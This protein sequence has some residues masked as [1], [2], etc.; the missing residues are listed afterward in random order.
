MMTQECY[1]SLANT[2]RLR[3]A[4][5]C[6]ATRSSLPPDVEKSGFRLV[7]KHT[8]RFGVA[9]LEARITSHDFWFA[10]V[11]NYGQMARDRA[12]CSN[13]SMK[14][15]SWRKRSFRRKRLCK[16]IGANSINPKAS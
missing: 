8:I 10:A 14:G 16:G 9:E 6:Q 2:N 15:H 12:A 3:Q 4:D 1:G 13:G 5:V 7:A 11:N